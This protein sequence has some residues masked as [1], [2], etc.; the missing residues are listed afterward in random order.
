MSVAVESEA[1]FGLE[2]V[3][4]TTAMHW[5][6]LHELDDRLLPALLT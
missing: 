3:G 5:V 2:R 6:Q 4:V 1:V